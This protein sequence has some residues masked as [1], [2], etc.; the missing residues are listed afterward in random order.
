M[1][2]VHGT[3]NVAFLRKRFKAMAA[4]HCYD[5]M[6][7]SEDPKKIADWVPLVMEGRTGDDPVA[8]TRIIT[9][10]DVDYG[11]LTHHLVRYLVA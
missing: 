11:S 1:S 2:F 8:A 3:D 4:H 6:E 7:Y 10:T 5:G 9:G